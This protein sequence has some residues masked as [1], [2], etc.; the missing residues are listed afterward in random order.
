MVINTQAEGEEKSAFQKSY[1]TTPRRL[2]LKPEHVA[3]MGK[4]VSFTPAK[5]NTGEGEEK[6]IITSSG[7]YVITW[8]FRRVKA[9]KLY[10]YSIK[11][12][13]EDVVAD[14]FK[15]GADK[16]IIVALA[17]NVE[18]T[19]KSQLQTPTKL[20]KSRHDIVNSPY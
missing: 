4:N 9:G 5:F 19:N 18:M 7:P 1:K 14:N 20:L 16:S 10:D 6:T 8:N 2:Q 13:S 12:Y 17:S 11:M 3:W 15:F